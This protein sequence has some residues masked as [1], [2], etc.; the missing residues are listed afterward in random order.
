[1]LE[2]LGLNQRNPGSAVGASWPGLYRDLLIE[3]GRGER[4]VFGLSLLG[5]W[6]E[7]DRDRACGHAKH[8]AGSYMIA[9]TAD[10][11]EYEAVLQFSFDKGLRRRGDGWD[12]R[13]D[14]RLTAGKGA[15]RKEIVFEAIRERLPLL[16][17]DGVVD[18]GW[19]RRGASRR[20]RELARGPRSIRRLRVDPSRR[21]TIGEERETPAVTREIAP[22]GPRLLAVT[23][24]ACSSSGTRTTRSA[25]TLRV[26]PVVKV[27]ADAWFPRGAQ[28]RSVGRARSNFR[29]RPSSYTLSRGGSVQAS[30]YGFGRSNSLGNFLLF[31]G[32]SDLRIRSVR[33]FG[34]G[35]LDGGR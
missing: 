19:I 25:S 5:A 8:S 29:E 16:L 20:Y 31:R 17:C 15:V 28:P 10:D 7:V 12:L 3:V 9:A 35:D 21:E 23:C 2:D 30:F 32:G 13:H 26:A 14:G 18:L 4:V 22:R 27:A 1:M 6:D 33:V 24:A 34:S 11:G